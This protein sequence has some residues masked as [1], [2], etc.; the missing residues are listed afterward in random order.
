MARALAARPSVVLLDEPFGALDPITRGEIRKEF[1][2]LQK[3]LETT[4][5]FVTHD[6]TEAFALGD[7]IGL[8]KDV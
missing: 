4:M 7:R 2:A 5:V 8:M 6:V 1:R 3:R